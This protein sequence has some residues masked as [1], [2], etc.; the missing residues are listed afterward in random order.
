MSLNVILVFDGIKRKTDVLISMNAKKIFIPVQKAKH[1]S[2]HSSHLNAIQCLN[3]KKASLLIVLA[4]VV[5]VSIKTRKL[6]AFGGK[7]RFLIKIYF[8]DEN[9]CMKNIHKCGPGGTCINMYGGYTCLCSTGYRLQSS[10]NGFDSECIGVYLLKL[11]FHASMVKA[12]F[13]IFLFP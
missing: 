9:E 5:L 7:M 13:R 1:A 3:A 2:T 8:L 11:K 6:L 4:V 12:I 10:S